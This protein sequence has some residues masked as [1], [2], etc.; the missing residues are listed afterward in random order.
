MSARVECRI[1]NT[2]YCLASEHHLLR[3]GR[4]QQIACHSLV[5]LL[6][7]PREGWLLWDTGYAP[8]MLELTRRW[9]ASLYR[10]V[11]PLYLRPE[12]AGALQALRKPGPCP[13]HRV[14][15]PGVAD[16]DPEAFAQLALEPG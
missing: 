11:T 15:F 12:L 4:R 7:H 13:L 16:A 3:G 14:S 8:R 5:A 6:R 10:R 2:G 1:L 9:P